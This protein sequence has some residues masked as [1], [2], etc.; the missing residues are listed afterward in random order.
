MRVRTAARPSK[1]HKTSELYKFAKIIAELLY[2]FIGLHKKLFLNAIARMNNEYGSEVNTDMFTYVVDFVSDPSADMSYVRAY[3]QATGHVTFQIP[4]LGIELEMKR[5]ERLYF[6][7]TET[8][9]SCKYTMDQIRALTN[10]AGL[11][12]TDKWTDDQHHA[13]ICRCVKDVNV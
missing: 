7:E 2:F 8:G 5:N 4:G 1:N 13:V 6:H 10:R 11:N 12:L 9:V 3:I